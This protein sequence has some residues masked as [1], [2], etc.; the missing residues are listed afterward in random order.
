MKGR[1]HIFVYAM[2]FVLLL[3]CYEYGKF[4]TIDYSV[5]LNLSSLLLRWHILSSN[6]LMCCKPFSTN[7]SIILKELL[8][9]SSSMFGGFSQ[10]ISCLLWLND[11]YGWFALWD[12]YMQWL[13]NKSCKVQASPY[14]LKILTEKRP[15]NMHKGLSTKE[16]YKLQLI[17]IK[18]EKT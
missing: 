5:V 3:I 8:G 17:W 13:I 18:K 6:M 10:G 14:L 1:V 7:L 11:L 9:F 15:P 16:W 12:S 4:I 2:C